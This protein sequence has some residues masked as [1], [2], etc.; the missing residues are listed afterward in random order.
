VK[1]KEGERYWRII[2]PATTEKVNGK[3]TVGYVLEL[4]VNR[5]RKRNTEA[6]TFN[7]RLTIRLKERPRMR[8]K[9]ICAL[10]WTVAPTVTAAEGF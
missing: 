7:A 10:S 2:R 5:L 1:P 4:T 8:P 3:Q 6:G 9:T